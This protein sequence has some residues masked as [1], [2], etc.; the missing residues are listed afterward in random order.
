MMASVA[1]IAIP[2]AAQAQG[3]W[4]DEAKLGVMDHD[5][6]LFDHHIEPG[7]DINGELLFTSP[8]FLRAI[9]APRLHLGGSVN[10][11]GNTS[12]AYVG[13]TWTAELWGSWFAGFGLGGAIHDGETTGTI[14]DH[15]RLG[16]RVLF[17]ESLEPGY[18][19]TTALSLSL[20]LD[21]MSNA[22]LARHNAGLTNF[23]VR[24]GY[25]F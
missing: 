14:P 24:M 6:G 19:L 12:Y 22:N 21:H 20:F 8:A 25:K 10:T 7:A 23:G 13:L 3:Q 16:A 15:K 2:S 4:I 11:S 5:I 1:V 18:R 9:G 17:H